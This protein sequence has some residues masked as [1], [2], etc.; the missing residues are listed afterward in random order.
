MQWLKR[1]DKD[2]GGLYGML[3]LV[4]GMPIAL[5]D[6]IDRNPEKQLLKGR[7]GYVNGWVLH[8]EESSVFHNGMRIL[9][10]TPAIV[11]VRYQELVGQ[12]AEATWQNCKW[13]IGGLPPGI[14]PIFPATRRWFLDQKRK[15]PVL[16]IHR[17]QLPLAPHFAITA[18]AAQGQTLIAAIVDLRIGRGVSNL[19]SYIAMTRIRTRRDVIIFRDF[20]WKLFTKGS[21]I[22]PATLLKVLRGE[23]IDWDALDKEF[24]PHR[25]C[26]V[27]GEERYQNEFGRVQWKKDPPCCIHCEKEKVDAGLRQ[28]PRCDAWEDV[29]SFC[30]EA[31]VNKR[32]AQCRMCREQILLNREDRGRKMC[33]TCKKGKF[34]RRVQQSAVAERKRAVMRE[35]FKPEEVREL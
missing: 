34:K 5:T 7:V 12:G 28:C 17:H 23:K 25:T 13:T 14:Y 2:C 27:C 20:D 1:H 22:G 32:N 18:H 16:L 26:I 15:F 9:K 21:D 35:L 10:N 31:L 3:M 6:H 4:E 30:D 11:F 24:T 8:K 33:V 29:A 19:A